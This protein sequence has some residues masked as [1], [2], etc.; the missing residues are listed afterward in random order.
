[1]KSKDT[2]ETRMNGN[3]LFQFI[4][5]ALFFMVMLFLLNYYNFVHFRFQFGLWSDYIFWPL[6][7]FMSQS[8]LIAFAITMYSVGRF[9]QIFY[10]FS[11]VW[12]GFSILCII[13][14]GAHDII[15]LF[16]PVNANVTVKLAILIAVV[17]SG[18]R[19]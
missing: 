16:I 14:L 12:L 11:M 9:S 7:I 17:L 18:S 4:V 15:R 19:I 2:T 13:L 8:M 6:F 3:N 5:F 10:F 1:M